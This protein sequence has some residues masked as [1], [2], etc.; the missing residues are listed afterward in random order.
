MCY[1]Q[2][3]D[4]QIIRGRKGELPYQM[5]RWIA[6]YEDDE[7]E[8]DVIFYETPIDILKERLFLK[9][10]TL[11]VA[12][13]AFQ[14]SVEKEIQYLEES[15]LSRFPDLINEK[16]AILNTLDPDIWINELHEIF[17]LKLET[18]N[19]T[20]NNDALTLRKFMLENHNGWYGFPGFDMGIALRLAVE[21]LP[22]EESLIYDVT[23]LISSG[24]YD[25]ETDLVTMSEEIYANEYFYHG[26]TII[27]TEG[28]T[29]SFILSES[30]NLLYP[31]LTSNFTFLDFEN[32]RIGGGVG[33]LANI[34][35]AFAG[36]GIIN[37]IIA[38]FDNDSASHT[39]IRKLTMANIPENIR[40][41][42]LPCM[43]FLTSYPTLGPSGLM[44]LD[45]NGFAASIE[46]YLGSDSLKDKRENF[47]PVQWKGY[48]ESIEQYQGEITHKKEVQDFFYKKLIICKQDNSKIS[49]YD[50]EGIHKI[51]Q[52]LFT[53][54]HD[55]DA[56]NILQSINDD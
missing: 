19:R 56:R 13:N 40:I 1:F 38:L 51:L 55:I 12:K 16:L 49:S 34:V 4:R 50:W 37:R 46:L 44:D 17:L 21:A 43:D 18:N 8:I 26:K 24:Y 54:F 29:D 6:Y 32:A 20:N 31:H 9:G 2:P 23:E 27:L 30:L 39:A 35:K 10:Y 3:Q 53:T 33:N 22:E 5:R 52:T 15:L 14:R 7:E 11:E 41:V 48:E 28:S 36:S 42:T 45:V 25:I 47:F